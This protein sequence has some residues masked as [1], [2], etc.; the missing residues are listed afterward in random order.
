MTAPQSPAPP[1]LPAGADSTERAVRALRDSLLVGL[2]TETVYG[3]AGDATS[4]RAVAAIFAAKDRPR[5]NPL[6]VHVAETA[7]AR[8]LVRFDDRAEALAARFWPGPLTLV[9]PRLADSGVSLLCSAGLD[10]LAVR[11]PRHEVPRAVIRALGRPVAAPS[12]NPSGKV[13]PT[14]AQHVAAGLGSKVALVIDGGPCP[15]GVESTVLD[16]TGPVPVLLRPGGAPEEEIEAALGKLARPGPDGPV[17][18]PGML[19]SHYAP[20]LPLRVEARDVKPDEA[21]LAFGPD[22]PKGARMTLNLSPAGDVVEAAQHLF[23]YLR[24]LDASGARAIA[25]MP[26]PDRGLGRAINDRLRRAA[27]ETMTGRAADARLGADEEMP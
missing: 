23:D 2:P 5:F 3:L 11:C 12:A 7:E 9:L 21:L 1:I 6:I 10:T 17:K 14:T 4:D 25:A 13:S 26:V 27:G 16:L 8:R 20:R 15:V 19:A 18:S 24:R 22:V